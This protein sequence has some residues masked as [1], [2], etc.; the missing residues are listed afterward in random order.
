MELGVSSLTTGLD[1]LTGASTNDT[2]SAVDAAAINNVST[3]TINSGDSINA[4]AGTDRLSIVAST[5]S[6][7]TSAQVSS[8][9]VEEVAVYNNSAAAYAADTTLMTGLTD[10]FVVAGINDVSF[11]GVNSSPNVHLT[12]VSNDV[13]VTN[14]ATVGL[15][16]ADA[17][18]IALNGAAATAASTLTYNDIETF[19]VVTSGAAT[20]NGLLPVFGGRSQTLT[21][22]QLET[23]NVSGSAA[24]NITVAMTGAALD[25]QVGTLDASD[26]TG[27]LTA[28]V[29]AG[30]SG[31]LSVTGGSGAD[32]LYVNSGA[33][34]SDLT[35][36]GGDGVDTLVVASAAYDKTSTTGQ[37]GDGVTN[38]EVLLVAG[39]ADLRS[40]SNNTFAGLVSVGAA[41]IAGLGA[42]AV[43]LTMTAAGNQTLDRATD[44]TADAAT[45]SFAGTSA[46][47]VASLNV[48]DEEAVTINSGSVLAGSNAITS[49]VG[50]DLTSLTIAG[51]RDLTISAISGTKLATVDASGLSG[52]G[53]QLVISGANSTADM[54]VT[55][56]AG[57]AALAADV[58]NN[59]TT[60]AG[61]DAITTGDYNDTINAGNGDNTVVAGDGDNVI[62][63]GRGDDTIT[64][65]DGDNTI[66]AGSGDNTVTVGDGDNGLT[67]GNGDDTVTT[68]GTTTSATVMDVNTVGL[69]AGDDTFTGGA[70]RD[71]VTMGTGDDTVDTGAGADSIYM[72]DYDDDDVVNGGAGTDALSASALA[73]ATA[74]ALTGAQIQAAA[75]HVD[76]TPGTS[77]TSSPQITGVESVYINANIAA[78]NDGAV[79]DRETIDLTAAT[80]IS[81]LYLLTTDPDNTND[82]VLILNETDAAAIHLQDDGAGA[83]GQLTVVGTGQASLT[84]K[85]HDMADSTD[86]VVTE[87]DALT[88]TSYVDNATAAVT[89]TVFGNITA[90]ESAGITVTGAG[91]SN[92][93]GAQAFSTGTISADAVETLTLSAGSN[94]TLTVGAIDTAGDELQTID[95]NVSDD[96]VMA[97]TSIAA[98]AGDIEAS[99]LT[100][101]VGVGGTFQGNGAIPSLISADS[102]ETATVTVGAA[103]TMRADFL[104]AGTTTIT[105][106]AGSTLDIDDIGVASLESSTTIS[107][108]ATL[109]GDLDLLGEATLNFSGLTAS[110]VTIDGNSAGDKTIVGNDSANTLNT[111]AGDDSVTG[112]AVI[113]T[114]STAAGDDTINGG[115]GA[116]EIDAG[117]GADVVNG[118]LGVDTYAVSDADSVVDTGTAV[119][120]T[121]AGIDTVTVTTG[122]LFNFADRTEALNADAGAA[123]AV[124]LADNTDDTTMT[125]LLAAMDAAVNADLAADDVVLFYVTD[126]GTG[127]TNSWT[128][129][130]LLSAL[131]G[132][133]SANDTLIKIVGTGVDANSTISIV[134]TEVAFAI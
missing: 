62:T 12:S 20:G 76:V 56:A 68:G 129:A 85:G 24:A 101:D 98:T 34:N 57:V 11:T 33:M 124:A 107:G 121:A 78:L 99:T 108:R 65:G 77:R 79:L 15:G 2:F 59:I 130:Y 66:N 19:N 38:M 117:T 14:A 18:T 131:D 31:L 22:D 64:A 48:A 90:D 123:V 1:T 111:G 73:S 30:V 47:T 126:S 80:G 46:F 113:D 60:G 72:S 88:V 83:L 87:V 110:A 8:S 53:T 119:T 115:A 28:T 127:G 25:A 81:N 29:G 116:D 23:V 32:T 4:G 63:T 5:G 132:I 84:L 42:D 104:Y 82:S 105:A 91:V 6:A 75:V 67:L 41:S 95:I 51:S 102:I 70:G 21:S 122:D 106:A 39:S 94:M 120:A 44:G 55:G 9:T 35:I 16:D 26:M 45:V 112:G 89:D 92:V 109:G 118:G 52:L 97:L 69:G 100:I 37:A 54:T 43:A 103:A 36:D 49:L 71:V 96:G 17:V 93:I 125:E 3:T 27:A 128:G 114:I 61:D 86:L 133:V 40:F 13:T 74:Q 50:T 7:T 58:M 10:L 134:A